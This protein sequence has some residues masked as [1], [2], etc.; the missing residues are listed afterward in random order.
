M[1]HMKQ[2]NVMHH[3]NGSKTVMGLY[4]I[5]RIDSLVSGFELFLVCGKDKFGNGEQGMHKMGKV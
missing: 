2:C 1:K 5:L 3:P 4:K